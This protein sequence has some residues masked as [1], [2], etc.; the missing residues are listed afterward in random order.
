MFNKEYWNSSAS[1]LKSVK[2]LA[3]MGVF[4]ALKI[5][6]S[7]LYF[8]VSE[9]LKVGFGFVLL[10]IESSILGP[11]AGA[12]SA[13]ITDNLGFFLG[14]GGVYFAGY[15]LTPVLAC[16][17]WSCFL[18]KQKITVVKIVIAKLINSLF[19]N[20]VV[21]SLWSSMLYGKGYIFYFTKSLI[22]NSLLFP[23]E[24]ILLVIVFNALAPVLKRY[25]LIDSSNTF[26]IPWI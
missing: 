22:K 14:G 23:I 13:I 15:T 12:L 10:A 18:Y 1:K 21:G 16:F 7:K 25:K 17:V 6:A 19:V 24:V 9:N 2:Y 8:P 4:I 20:V 26:P 3:L 5:V 11:V